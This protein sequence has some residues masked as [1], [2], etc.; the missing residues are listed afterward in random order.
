MCVHLIVFY[1]RNTS[2]VVVVVE[3]ALVEA[4]VVCTTTTITKYNN[5]VVNPICIDERI[6]QFRVI[7]ISAR[8]SVSNIQTKLSLHRCS[9]LNFFSQLS[10]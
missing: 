9:Q 3:G 8:V 10:M 5:N 6:L 4:T 2:V 7:I 1:L